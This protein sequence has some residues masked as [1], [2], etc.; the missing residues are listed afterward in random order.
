MTV[1]SYGILL[2]RGSPLPDGSVKNLEVFLI[3]PNGPHVWGST[4]P[5]AW[6]FPK[7]RKEKGEKPLEVA[8]REFVEEVGMKAPKNVV[9]SELEPLVTYSG[10]VITIFSADATGL[11][12]RWVE[13]NVRDKPHVMTDEM[14]GKVYHSSYK[15]TRDGQWFPVG[16]ALKKIGKGQRH[17]LKDFLARQKELQKTPI[18][19]G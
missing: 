9:Y 7:G 13:A 8:R 3:K 5:D 15:E 2:Y 4:L 14:T 19:Q 1:Y 17:I 6:G 18:V 10:K 16:T 12:I 11:P